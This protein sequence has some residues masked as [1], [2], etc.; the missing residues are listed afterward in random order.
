MVDGPDATAGVTL[1]GW[2]LTPWL[3]FI[4][5]VLKGINRSL[6]KSV[7]ESYRLVVHV[8]LLLHSPLPSSASHSLLRSTCPRH[9]GH[10][11]ARSHLATVARHESVRSVDWPTLP[12]AEVG[13]GWSEVGP[14]TLSR[15]SS[16]HQVGWVDL[17]LVLNV[18]KD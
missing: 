15:K 10:L 12:G 2:F 4:C 6:I 16:I 11:V 18:I 3:N 14:L 8:A 9:V 1:A 7:L 5:H 13:H 17:H